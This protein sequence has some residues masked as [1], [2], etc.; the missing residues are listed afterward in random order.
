MYIA[1]NRNYCVSLSFNVHVK[2][3]QLMG[4]E[5]M[6]SLQQRMEEKL[7]QFQEAVKLGQEEVTAK[8]LE[9]PL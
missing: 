8:A 5:L 4:S 7:A 1:F 9:K 2:F 3:S 6:A